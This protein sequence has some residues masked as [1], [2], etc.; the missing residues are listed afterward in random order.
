MGRTRARE[1]YFSGEI[2]PL[3]PVPGTKLTIPSVIR[4]LGSRDISGQYRRSECP[5][6]VPYYGPVDDRAARLRMA[7]SGKACTLC[8]FLNLTPPSFEFHLFCDDANRFGGQSEFSPYRGKGEAVASAGI[9][10]G[11][12]FRLTGRLTH[13]RGP[14][15]TAI[16][17]DA[18]SAPISNGNL[19]KIAHDDSAGASGV[20]DRALFAAVT[21]PRRSRKSRQRPQ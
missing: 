20:P 11:I 13:C 6:R 7:N 2:V 8:R 3:Q 10:F 17:P 19:F 5:V 9:Y 21:E 12:T 14:H 18:L 4:P 16:S 15:L 1:G